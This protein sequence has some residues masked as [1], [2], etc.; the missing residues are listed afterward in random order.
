MKIQFIISIPTLKN[1]I[2]S[3]SGI[4]KIIPGGKKYRREHK[5]I[6]WLSIWTSIK[7]YCFYKVIMSYGL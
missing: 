5:T 4:S 1:T 7:H 2:V 6:E 3:F